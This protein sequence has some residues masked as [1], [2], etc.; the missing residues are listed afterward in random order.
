MFKRKKVIKVENNRLTEE[1]MERLQEIMDEHGVN[2]KRAYEIY[3]E[4]LNG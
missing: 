3:E 2:L 1:A 4:E